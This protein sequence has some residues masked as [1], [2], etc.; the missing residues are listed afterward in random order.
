MKGE[1]PVVRDYCK[2][3]TGLVPVCTEEND[4]TSEVSFAQYVIYALHSL[5]E[6]ITAEPVRE[7]HFASSPSAD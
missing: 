6:R 5:G 2:V 1:W 4:T 7:T 3:N